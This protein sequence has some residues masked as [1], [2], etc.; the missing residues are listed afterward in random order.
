ML[1]LHFL[2]TTY[3]LTVSIMALGA[4]NV[5]SLAATRLNSKDLSVECLC[6]RVYFLVSCFCDWMCKPDTE[7]HQRGQRAQ[8]RQCH[9]KRDSIL[10]QFT[11]MEHKA[12]EEITVNQGGLCD[13]RRSKSSVQVLP[14]W[15]ESHKGTEISEELTCSGFMEAACLCG[16]DWKFN[17]CVSNKGATLT[18]A[19][20]QTGG[21][22]LNLHFI[23]VILL[24]TNKLTPEKT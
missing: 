22:G 23:L 13:K 14:I 12:L 21:T 6:A 17:L 4:T 8:L 7:Q 1:F 2:C 19:D 16:Y 15:P 10:R 18:S 20:R 11:E 5:S 24:S 3:V 9:T